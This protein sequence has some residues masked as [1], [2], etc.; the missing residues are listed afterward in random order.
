M[1]SHDQKNK[2]KANCYL[3]VKEILR[4]NLLPLLHCRGQR[5][6]VQQWH[7][8]VT[9]DIPFSLWVVLRWAKEKNPHFKGKV[10]AG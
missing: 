2:K 7:I 4:Q 3:L 8:I 1:L 6:T 10:D 9:Y 5:K